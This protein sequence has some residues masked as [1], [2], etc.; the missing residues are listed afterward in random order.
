MNSLHVLNWN[1]ADLYS[2]VKTALSRFLISIL[3]IFLSFRNLLFMSPHE[4]IAPYKPGKKSVC[5]VEMEI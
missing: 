2:G 4:P 3:S 5:P 1:T